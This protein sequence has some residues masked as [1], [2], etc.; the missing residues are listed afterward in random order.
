MRRPPSTS[1]VGRVGHR[2]KRTLA[3]APALGNFEQ[4]PNRKRCSCSLADLWTEGGHGSSRVEPALFRYGLTRLPGDLLRLHNFH[5][6]LQVQE[7]DPSSSAN[8]AQNM[9][10][11]RVNNS[12]HQ[13][14]PVINGEKT[15]HN[16]K[17][18]KAFA[19]EMVDRHTASKL[20]Q[21]KCASTK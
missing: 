3:T 11:P 6:S 15:F 19:A 9:A 7:N 20:R 12:D 18:S 21:E 2:F 4:H 16:A 10:H 13:Q 5:G 14:M 17:I 1:P 8:E